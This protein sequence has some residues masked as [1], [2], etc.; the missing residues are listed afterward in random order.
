M[1][2]QRR[3]SAIIRFL[4]SNSPSFIFLGAFGLKAA[5]ALLV[6]IAAS[7]VLVSC[8]NNYSY[9]GAGG[10]QIDPAT[11][12]V[13]VFVSNP[14]FPNGSSTAA[15]LNV[16]DGQRDLLSPGVISV[17][18]TSPTPGLMALFPNKRFTLIY[19]S[20]NNSISLVNNQS[21]SLTQ[22]SSGNSSSITLPGFSE[23]IVIAP[24]N[25][26]GFAAVPTASVT[27]GT[28][29]PPGEVEVLNLTN[30][31]ITA[32][33]PVAGAHYLAQSHNGNRLLVLG[34]RA[35]TVT[36][37]APSA[38]GTSTDPRTDIQSPLFDH[39]VW[40]IFSDDDSTAYILN[41]GPECGGT[42]ASVTLLDLNSNL[43]GPTIPV[44]AATSGLLSA[45]TL[46]VA[47]TR[48]GVNTCAGSATPT[49]ATTCGEVSV[50]NLNSNTVSATATITDGYHNR[51]EMGSN[52]QLFIGARTCTNINAAGTGS[53]PGEVR[54]CLSIFDTVKST[55]V[56]PARIG[57]VSGIQPISRR[58]VVY[59]AINGNVSIFDTTTDQ[60]QATQ[61][62]IIGQ[63]VDVK[64]VD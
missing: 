54:G 2:S 10:T 33:V 51:M 55:A 21:Q 38:V 27:P 13:H 28:G 63:A 59:V 61:V 56:I 42:A 31:V 6:L 35:D 12:K 9:Q 57:D 19:S 23:S 29:L 5:L 45:N 17:G 40:A 62:D 8:G 34:S 39:P 41:C 58:N 14:L 32:G 52:N 43:V 30:G 48:P 37:I 44:D 16:V 50:V 11:I 3:G 49:L 60:L 53:S 26:T 36:L 7:A 18:A 46:Y 24:D 47:G 22:N 15:V 4:A 1:H 64:Q 20:S 25:I